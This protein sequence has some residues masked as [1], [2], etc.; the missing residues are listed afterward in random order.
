MAWLKAEVVTL[1]TWFQ[2]MTIEVSRNPEKNMPSMS[3]AA[4][5]VVFATVSFYLVQMFKAGRD[6]LQP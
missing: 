3:A 1:L 4:L 2:W 5:V 6:P